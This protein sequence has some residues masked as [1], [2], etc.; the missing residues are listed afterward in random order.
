MKIS[1]L[2]II[3]TVITVVIGYNKK[4]FSWGLFRLFTDKG[5][6]SENLDRIMDFNPDRDI[7][8]LPKLEGKGL[9]QSIDDLSICRKAQVRKYIYIYL[10]RGRRYLI[11][12]ISRSH[13]YMETI[14]SVFNGKNGLP[15]DL[16]LLPLLESGFNP[17]AVSRSNAIGL[18]QFLFNTSKHLDLRV[19]RWVDERRD[20]KKSTIAAARHLSN[21]Y[22]MFN[23]W[24]LA[25][26]AYN[27]GG[28]YLKRTLAKTGT[29]DIWE[30]IDSGKLREETRQY[31]PR[32]IA[33]AVIYK[34]RGL[35]GIDKEIPEDETPV[36][37]NFILDY[38]VK[39]RHISRFSGVP[40]K[41]IR[42]FNPQLRRNITPPGFRN[43]SI[44]LPAD[45][46]EELEKNR[47]K[48]NRYRISRIKTYRVKRGDSLG[49]IA[50]RFKK[51]LKVLSGLTKSAIQT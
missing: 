46:A 24:P 27:G 10:T 17:R 39:L 36:T 47:K 4:V 25:L 18:W 7:L 34:H 35:F 44:R 30:L 28:G 43:Y 8:Y 1:R 15:E 26:A 32:F 14:E 9:F 3:A 5:Y 23:S 41:K 19:N 31:L 6:K 45:A 11:N 29:T 21:L 51:K 42:E 48:L 2:I 16:K 49:G 38:P 40:E 33:L 22:K 13:R 12:G 50:R 20:I 37:G